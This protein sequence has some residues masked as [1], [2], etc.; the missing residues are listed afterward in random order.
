LPYSGILNIFPFIFVEQGVIAQT[1]SDNLNQKWEIAPI[2]PG[3]DEFFIINRE[4]G[5]PLMINGNTINYNSSG[6][7]E[8]SQRFK[9]KNI[10]GDYFQIQSASTAGC[11][12]LEQQSYYYILRYSPQAR[13]DN[14]SYFKL[15]DGEDIYGSS[16]VSS[17]NLVYQPNLLFDIPEPPQLTSYTCSAPLYV[18]ETI[19]GE[20]W[21]PFSLVADISFS[22]VVQ[23]SQTPYYKLIR[24]QAWK[25]IKDYSYEPGMGYTKTYKMYQGI[26]EVEKQ[27]VQNTLEHSW[28]IQGSAEFSLLKPV[29]K[30]TLG[31]SYSNKLSTSTT[32]VNEYS[33][34][35]WNEITE[36][37]VFNTT[38]TVRFVVYELVDRY[39][40]ERMDGS[41]AVDPWEIYYPE[42]DKF[43]TYCSQPIMISENP[44]SHQVTII[45]D[46]P[47]SAPQNLS[48][49]WYNNH[50]KLTWDTNGELDI[51]EYK[52]WKYAAGSSMIVATV[53]HTASNTTHSWIDN[54]VSKP[55]KFDTS[56]E[57][58]Y[59]V[60]AIDNS[61]Q[62]SLYS[63]QVSISGTGGIWKIN[64]EEDS[65]T[66]IINKFAL[67]SNY[68]NPFNP[69]TQ[70]SY[71]L[72]E[73][74]FVNLVVYNTIGQKVAEL[75]NQEQTSGKYTVKFD[76]AD[77]PS[78]VY[79]YKFQAGEFSDV[80]KMLLTK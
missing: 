48:I 70:I 26:T 29:I 30:A 46:L 5:Y 61:N 19:I 37:L 53:T 23:V 77:L 12:Y 1:N 36:S 63:N 57:Y 71:Q 6:E 14:S 64:D 54:S 28:S 72:P 15:L 10:N 2:Y 76:A 16:N 34:V 35:F 27:T 68:P 17:S 3:S 8:D 32:L 38:T 78:G 7:T 65:N 31:A 25:K 49:A 33:A 18:N 60:K 75:V 51:K 74:S 24:K 56:I 67:E 69:T 43:R 41:N 73:N 59:K 45:D 79:I 62:E 21:V 4:T 55:G 11:L 80:K 13:N 42:F 20:S 39:S 9:F 52:I 66:E 47:P 58:S 44:S 50:P 40:L 22:P